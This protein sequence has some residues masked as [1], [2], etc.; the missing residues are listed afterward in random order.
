MPS[1]DVLGQPQRTG[2]GK[3]RR[4]AELVD[5]RGLQVKKVRHEEGG[6]TANPADLMIVTKPL[7]EPKVVQL[8][9]IMGH[10]F[11]GQHLEL[12]GSHC[13]KLVSPTATCR[14]KF[15][16]GIFAVVHGAASDKDYWMV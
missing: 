16:R 3:T 1:D 7:P 5:T 14:M 11:V 12:E 9:T 6:T 13:T 8:M 2:Q 15:D 4:R 10:K